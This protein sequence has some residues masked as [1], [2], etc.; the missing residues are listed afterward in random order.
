MACEMG[1]WA[2]IDA[3]SPDERE[4]YLRRLK[5]Q[6]EAARFA[7]DEPTPAPAAGPPEGERKP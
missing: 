4:R 1:F 5:E 2:M 6:E 3:L 7:C